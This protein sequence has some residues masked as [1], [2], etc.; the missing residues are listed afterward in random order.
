MQNIEENKEGKVIAKSVATSIELQQE[1]ILKLLFVLI[2]VLTFVHIVAEYYFLYWRLPWFDIVTHFLGGIWVGLAV[3]WFYYYSGY[4]RP[5]VFPGKNMVWTVLGLGL[6]IGLLWEGY[7]VAVWLLSGAGLP[8]P[9][10]PD[11]VLDIIVDVAG[12]LVSAFL[13]Q[14]MI[15]KK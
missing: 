15:L 5:P 9:Y 8:S 7:E 4:L 6:A 14:K 13:S 11:T 1:H 10:M 12:V 3:I 2:W